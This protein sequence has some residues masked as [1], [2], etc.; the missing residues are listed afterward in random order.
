MILFIYHY[1]I[2]FLNEFLGKIQLPGNSSNFLL[3]IAHPDDE[4]MFFGPTLLNLI[5]NNRGSNIRILLL[6]SGQTDSHV[7]RLLEFRTA[8]D[9]LQI[10]NISITP[11]FKDGFKH[12][13][14]IK[15]IADQI[16]Y[17]SKSF[18][19][20]TILTFDAY[21]VSGHPNHKA[22][23]RAA[24]NCCKSS[25]IQHRLH[26]KSVSVFRKYLGPIDIWYSV[27]VNKLCCSDSIVLTANKSQN[28]QI[29]EALFKHKSQMVWYRR[30]FYAQLS[31]YMWIND[32]VEITE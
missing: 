1:S 13:W 18:N 16:E 2:Y 15:L 12:N 4:C 30:L 21:G 23:Y 9:Y 26:L 7:D 32:L 6:S 29:K 5:A 11:L 31:R 8:C 10:T 20:D 28:Q 25:N 14:P 27:I 24:L 17:I 19:I 22:V 3:I